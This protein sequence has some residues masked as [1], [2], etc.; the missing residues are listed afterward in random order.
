MPFLRFWGLPMADEIPDS[1]WAAVRG[2]LGTVGFCVVLIGAELIKEREHVLIGVALVVGGL[3]VFLSA[4][5]WKW[6]RTKLGMRA[7]DALM[8]VAA[9]PRW[10]IVTALVFLFCSASRSLVLIG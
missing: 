9:D 10:W 8:S 2:Y 1:P 5:L 3:P 6:V 4:F 7:S